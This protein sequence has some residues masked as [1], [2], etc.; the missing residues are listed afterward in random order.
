[1]NS[2]SRAIATAIS[3]LKCAQATNGSFRGQIFNAITGQT[4]A[5][6]TFFSTPLILTALA[7]LKNRQD[8]EWQQLIQGA[9]R[10]IETQKQ[11]NGAF[12]YWEQHSIEESQ[13]PYPNDLDDTALGYATLALYQSNGLAG[14]E[15]AHL[16][17][18]LTAAELDIGGPYNTW[19]AN[20]VTDNRW[21]DCDP[22][23]NANIAYLLSLLD[24]KLPNLIKYF[25]HL[26]I[27][28]R[29]KSLYYLSP[30]T[31]L[32]FISRGY[33]GTRTADACASICNLKQN[34]HWESPMHTALALSV[35]HRFNADIGEHQDSIDYLLS[36]QQTDGSW[37]RA[38]C[39]LERTTDTETWLYGS[40][41]LSTAF[42]LEALS[43][44]QSTIRIKDGA[45]CITEQYKTTQE[46]ITG[47][48]L[49]TCRTSSL[50]FE[51]LASNTISELESCSFWNE[52]IL[53]PYLWNQ[54]IGGTAL[55]SVLSA[56]QLE[57]L[58]TA[59]LFGLIGYTLLDDLADGDLA[60][61][62]APFVAFALRQC[63]SRY[64]QL[65]SVEQH[66]L[67]NAQ[68]SAQE[69]AVSR[70]QT[71]RSHYSSN[72]YHLN[73][74]PRYETLVAA[75]KSVGLVLPALAIWLLRGVKPT[76]VRITKTI[77]FF[78]S[79]LGA[80][81]WNDDAHD[82]T[83]DLRQGRITPVGWHV[84]ESLRQQGLVIVNFT[85]TTLFL[86]A[87]WNEAFIKI[88]TCITAQLEQAKK[89]LNDLKLGNESY[90][91]ALIMHQEAILTYTRTER[92][93]TLSFLKTYS[94]STVKNPSMVATD[95]A[96]DRST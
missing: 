62:Q 22:G 31:L 77:G 79:L 89:H 80:R 94:T 35:L 58:G 16:A 27:E 41:V 12:N 53:L 72:I 3:Y 28:Q 5:S 57:R 45:Q 61:S 39:Y 7:P 90:F 65:V 50:Y 54:A 59:H 48:C 4:K 52:I 88:S 92:A 60:S 51:R 44:M 34:G 47:N 43:L 23:V 78:K 74:L 15:L 24:I 10:Y 30:I 32:Y 96:L 13:S 84:L 46:K 73:S 19:L 25:D 29:I 67:L 56:E 86:D 81:Q 64:A 95:A 1:M 9:C 93:R 82:L 68:L 20:F 66:Q 38:T 55:P 17:N 37:P 11:S 42:A 18:L 21:R 8:I 63:V 75:E 33:H 71:L 26:I 83:D 70:E 87:F 69:V 36:T 49:D 40:E 76:D 14:D 85:D 2:R 91:L 6:N